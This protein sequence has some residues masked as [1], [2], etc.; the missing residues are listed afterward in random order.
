[1]SESHARRYPSSIAELEAL[2]ETATRPGTRARLQARLADR[3]YHNAKRK[4]RLRAVHA[5]RSPEEVVVAQMARHPSG[6]KTCNGCKRSLAF[7]AFSPQ[8]E[9]TDGLWKYCTDC[10][11]TPST[12]GTR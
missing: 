1:M 10:Q 6:S 11:H 5:A 12:E 7:T 4:A 2:L 8:P 9:A 3:R